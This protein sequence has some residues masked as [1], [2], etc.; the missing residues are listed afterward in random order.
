MNKILKWIKKINSESDE[1]LR[2][3]LEV[4][5]KGNIKRTLLIEALFLILAVGLAVYLMP[6]VDIIP[7]P[8]NY[9]LFS[10][11]ILLIIGLCFYKK[12]KTRINKT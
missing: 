10:I 3:M 1:I 2:S 12:L 9:Y 6:N 4:R 8:L 11:V 7:E 5:K